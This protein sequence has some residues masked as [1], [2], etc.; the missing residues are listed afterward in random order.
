M[1]RTAGASEEPPVKD[2]VHTVAPSLASASAS[3]IAPP[4][5]R[6]SGAIQQLEFGLRVISASMMKSAWPELQ[7]RGR[8]ARKSDLHVGNRAIQLIAHLILD[9][10][11]ELVQPFRLGRIARDIGD[12]AQHAGRAHEQAGASAKLLYQPGGMG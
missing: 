2:A 8:P 6:S 7:P 3:S 12:V 9:E 4:I 5:W 1:R 11:D 10:L